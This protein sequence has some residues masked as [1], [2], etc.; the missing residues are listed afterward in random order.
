MNEVIEKEEINIKN[1]IYEIRGK[2]VMLDSDL[3]R[4]YKCSNG[5]KTINQAVK[6]HINRF[7]E[8]FMFQ[9]INEEYE[10]LWSQIGTA[11]N[12]MSRTNPYVF[13]EQGVAM[14]SSVLRTSVAEEVSI[15][16]MDAFVEMKKFISINLFNQ[17]YY[18]KMTVRH[19]NEIKLLQQS[20]N[21]LSVKKEYCGIFFDGQVYDS[22]S[23][24]IDIFNTAKK[25]IVIIDNY[26][27]K[28]LLD[29]LRDIN[30][31]ILIITNKFNNND[32][33]KYKLQYNNIK[34]KINNNIHD[35]FI[36]IDKK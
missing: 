8:R 16:I 1:M 30:K 31:D 36:I 13:T 11:K 25:D 29:V 20:F 23:L 9:L 24:L 7:P 4:L 26:I 32:Y 15:K 34:L 17:D 14:L 33:N 19:D 18:N 12:K 21:E 6:R 5:T 2:Y 28:S 10:N 27:D 35:R 3:A 22:Y